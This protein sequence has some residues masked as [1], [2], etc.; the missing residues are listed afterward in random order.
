ME[1]RANPDGFRFRGYFQGLGY[2]E[3]YAKGVEKG[4]IDALLSGRLRN[5]KGPRMTDR[6]E[7]RAPRVRD[8]LGPY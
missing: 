5:R 4:E 2:E 3:H 7:A 1:G 8:R 6:L